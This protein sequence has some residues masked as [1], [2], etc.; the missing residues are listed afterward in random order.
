[1]GLVSVIIPCYNQA[2]FLSEAIESVASQTYEPTETIVV[3]D[4]S[5]DDTS[6]VA[7]V[8]GVR[9]VRQE[10]RGLA[11]ARN[12]GLRASSGDMLLFLDADDLLAPDAIDAGVSCLISRPDAA[13]VF[14]RPEVVGLPH[15]WVPPL[16][17]GDYYRH[18]L[19]RDIIWMPGLVLYRRWIF[20]DVGSFN[21]RF[22]GAEDY[23]LYLRITLRHPI[24]FCAGMHGSYRHHDA[25]MS[26]DTLRMFR[27]K[28]AALRSQRKHV[29]D[30]KKYR[31]AYRTG[32][33]TWR[34]YYGRW[35]ILDTREQIGTGDIR[36]ALS[37]LAVLLRYDRRGFGSAIFGGLRR[38]A[39]RLLRARQSRA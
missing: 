15:R 1:M 2:H 7:D 27:A 26:S 35:V 25:N 39:A 37:G 5:T 11:E 32:I 29:R 17:E 22:D 14:G 28:S 9:C 31:D 21:R 18:L 19:E 36:T 4:G 20:D 16:V 13:L 12:T 10:N 33:K 24:A 8:H 30:N 3:D 6:H 38:A 34:Y 23:D